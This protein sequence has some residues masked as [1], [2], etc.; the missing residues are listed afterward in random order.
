[1]RRTLAISILTLRA[2]FRYRVFLVLSALLIA[3]VVLLPLLIK[4]D[5]SAQGFTQIILTY[6][7]TLAT[8]LLG[9]ASLW[10]S[11]G[12][13]A[14]EME[15]AQMQMVA[16][17]PISR[18]QI[19]IGKWLGILALN[20]MLLALTGIA[21]YATMTYRASKLPASEQEIL[22][23]EIFVARAS[24]SEPVE[25][26]DR[27]AQ[28]IVRE[29][30]QSG[31]PPEGLTVAAMR[32]M[33]REQ[34][35]ARD[36][37]VPPNYR[38]L[39][40][41][42]VGDPEDVRNR[43]MT[44]RAR[45]EPPV[46]GIESRFPTR[47]IVGDPNTNN[48]FETNLVMMGESYIEFP[49]PAATVNQD[50]ILFI[51]VDNFSEEPMLFQV[52]GGLEVLYQVGGFA[53]NFARGLAIVFCWLALLSALG[54]AG[55]TFLSFPVAAFCTIAILF[56]SLS[57]DT[58]QQ[59]IDEGG[60]VAVNTNTGFADEPN[61]INSFAVPAAKTLLGLFNL[62]RGFSP[63]DDLSSGRAVSWGE[64]SRAFFQIVVLLGGLLA[65]AGITIFTRRELAT[66]QK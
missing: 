18:W 34:L 27:I 60:V 26:Y 48:R 17:K 12:I 39:W 2:A 20:A 16:V 66:A 61:L 14:R 3:G 53:A 6:T 31:P 47:W 25:D 8:A 21:V 52:E 49:I 33:I 29:Q 50:G 44:I 62:A 64:L 41:I 65:A 38:K 19:W 30:L 55:A 37:L 51:T 7:L 28:E 45:V 35:K 54:L 23:R 36:Q 10:L 5:G 22:R 9:F 11:C 1:M 57:S 32:N 13:L 63:I 43:R 4:D 46:P 15:E 58:L 59:I 42:P 40:E 24:V 56:T